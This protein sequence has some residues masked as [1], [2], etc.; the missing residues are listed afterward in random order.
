MGVL[1]PMTLLAAM[2]LQTLATNIWMNKNYA[3]SGSLSLM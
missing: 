1:L 3:R 2:W